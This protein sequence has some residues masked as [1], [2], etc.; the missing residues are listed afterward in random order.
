M[1]SKDDKP[2]TVGYLKAYIKH[3]PDDTRV[4]AAADG[5]FSGA[6]Y[7][8]VVDDEKWN[9]GLYVCDEIEEVEEMEKGEKIIERPKL[10]AVCGRTNWFGIQN[11]DSPC[12][13]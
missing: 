12:G 10:C 3:L 9:S 4:F 5:C 2:I 7:L 6:V 11:Y 1:K 13:H 8:K